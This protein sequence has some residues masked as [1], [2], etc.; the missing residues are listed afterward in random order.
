[1][2]AATNELVFRETADGL[3]FVGDFESLYREDADPWEQS[4][5]GNRLRDY[6]RHSRLAIEEVLTRYF[7]G[8]ARG[9]EVGCGLGYV[10]RFLN[11]VPGWSVVGVD[12]SSEAIK[13]AQR[14]HLLLMQ[15]NPRRAMRESVH[16]QY[17]IGDI[18]AGEFSVP[19]PPYDFVILAQCWWYV[20]HKIEAVIANALACLKPGGLFI[21]S[22]A[23]LKG[24]QRYANDVAPGIRGALKL[25]EAYGMDRLI[26]LRYDDRDLLVHHDGLLVF[27]C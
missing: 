16:G 14:L 6:Y 22:Q 2:R 4:G 9:L 13:S 25:L 5:S 26:E 8:E 12:V 10:T 15:D 3:E 20:L 18:T 24:E 23:F 1:M 11:T 21:V 27:R 7:R 17:L 19:G